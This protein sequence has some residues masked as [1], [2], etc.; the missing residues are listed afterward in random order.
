MTEKIT[1]N[2]VLDIEGAD[3]G[4]Q[5]SDLKLD[6]H[7][8]ALSPQPSNFNDDPLVSIHVLVNLI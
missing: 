5:K 4:S 2:R 8:L 6:L 3:Q 7:G 1:V